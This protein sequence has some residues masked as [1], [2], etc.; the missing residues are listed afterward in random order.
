MM[1]PVSVFNEVACRQST[2]RVPSPYFPLLGAWKNLIEG[3]DQV[4]GVLSRTG[5]I[6][7]GKTPTAK[8]GRFHVRS[9]EH[10]LPPPTRACDGVA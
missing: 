3:V 9:D 7:T 5:M 8:T 4:H 10:Y 2:N 6:G 1:G